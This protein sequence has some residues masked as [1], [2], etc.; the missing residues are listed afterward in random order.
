M[1]TYL[2]ISDIKDSIIDDIDA[3][4][5]MAE[6]DE[7]IEDLAE[8]HDVQVADIE[9]DPLHYKIRRYGIAYTLMRLCQD[10]ISKA[11]TVQPPETNKYTILYGLY[12]RELKD[13]DNEISYEMLTGNVNTMRDRANMASVTIFRG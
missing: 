1:S 9:T 8:R 2:E 10:R 7:A 11:A 5:Y 4:P 6:A 13:L 3:S 12:K